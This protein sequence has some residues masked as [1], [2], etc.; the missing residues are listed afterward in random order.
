MV[1]HLNK[2]E[3]RLHPRT[4]WAKI[5]W[6]WPS[7]SGNFFIISSMYFASS[8]SSSFGNS[9]PLHPMMPCAVF[10]LKLA[11]WLWRI[12]LNKL[13]VNV[14][15][16]FRNYLPL[17]KGLV[18]HLNKLESYLAKHSLCQVWLKLTL[19]F[20]RRRW[21]CEKFTTTMR[22]QT[23]SERLLRL[24]GAKNPLKISLYKVF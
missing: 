7:N 19:W 16:P 1:L 10:W 14:F 2:L 5:G 21:I 8:L 17:G 24:R 22:R 23:T 13:I 15:S 20:W 4:L 11:Q 6:I 3:S 18:L 9:N 12:F